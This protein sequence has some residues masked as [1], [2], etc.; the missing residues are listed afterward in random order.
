MDGRTLSF[1]LQG[2]EFIMEEPSSCPGSAGVV[3]AS[4]VSNAPGMAGAF[5]YLL[6]DNSVAESPSSTWDIR[7]VLLALR[8]TVGGEEVVLRTQIALRNLP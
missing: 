6:A 8:A 3:L 5:A 7:G 4:G 1:R 2:S